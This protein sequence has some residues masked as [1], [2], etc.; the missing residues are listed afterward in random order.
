MPSIPHEAPLDLLRN[1]PD[2]AAALLAGS[3]IPVPDHAIATTTDSNLST[4]D[5]PEFRADAVTLLCGSDGKLAVIT[6]SQSDPPKSAKRRAWPAYVSIAQSQHKCDAVL[7][8]IAS[9]AT[10]ARAC[11]RLVRTGHPG[12]DLAP[13]VIGPDNTPDPTDPAHAAAAPELTILAILTHAIDLTDETTCHQVVQTLN[14]LDE[15][16][17]DTYTHFVRTAASDAARSLLEALMASKYKDDFIERYEAR[18]EANAVLRV[19]QARGFAISDSIRERVLSCSDLAQ[20]DQ[21]L[22]RAVT[23]DSIAAVF[24]P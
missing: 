24:Q 2:L 6:E 22:D 20:L 21:W 17:R 19:L 18:G 8:V 23:S 3:G 1:N 16:T 9:D 5:P 14:N 13:I 4:C 10:T 7:V 11:R 15:E 12:F